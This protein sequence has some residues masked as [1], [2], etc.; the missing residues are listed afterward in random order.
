MSVRLAIALGGRWIVAR[1]GFERLHAT[2]LLPIAIRLP[3][4][5]VSSDAS[6][7]AC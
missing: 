7:S 2:C 5:P 1:D 4:D 6:S 3:I